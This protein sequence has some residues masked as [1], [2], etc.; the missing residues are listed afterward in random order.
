MW[1]GCVLGVLRVFQPI[2]FLPVDK[3]QLNGV[4]TVG[5]NCADNGG[6]RQSHLAFRAYA[7]NNTQLAM[8]PYLVRKFTPEQ[9]FF[10]SYANVSVCLGLLYSQVQ[11]Y[12]NP[13]SPSFSRSGV[14]PLALRRNAS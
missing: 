12:F 13:L 3:T 7:E 1:V 11:V 4:N 2:L 9:V 14:A 6:V 8:V 10:L 5:E